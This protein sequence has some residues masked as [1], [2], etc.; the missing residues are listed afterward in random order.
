M[1]FVF[2]WSAVNS[3]RCFGNRTVRTKNTKQREKNNAKL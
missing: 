2:T 3:H 1:L